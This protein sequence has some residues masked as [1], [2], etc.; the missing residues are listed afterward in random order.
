MEDSPGQRQK[1]TGKPA[2]L[3][4]NINGLS[5]DKI[6]VETAAESKID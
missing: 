2:S 1:T 4:S 3:R 6:L 5:P